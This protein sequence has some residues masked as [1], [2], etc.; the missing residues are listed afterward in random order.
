MDADP[1]PA[2]RIEL[3]AP[4]ASRLAS[5]TLLAEF[6]RSTDLRSFAIAARGRASE[7]GAFYA[8]YAIAEC[9][10]R[11][12]ASGEVVAPR[13]TPLDH[14]R[15][16]ARVASAERWAMR[17]AAFL[18]DELSDDAL[19]KVLASGARA[20]DPLLPVMADWGRAVEDGEL[21]SLR[22]AWHAVLQAGDPALL[23]WAIQ[24]GGDYL[25]AIVDMD[26]AADEPR[27]SAYLYTWD[28]VACELGAGCVTPRGPPD[29]L[30]ELLPRCARERWD[31]AALGATPASPL[32]STV[33][34]VQR[35]IAAMR[36]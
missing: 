27:R 35:T 8:A 16:Q 15:E 29:A 1:Q 9:R 34:E 14:R 23:D 36:R 30:C 26:P 25:H 6:A 7:G 28:A 5:R 3:T 22:R 24:S 31:I 18:P 20:N 21:A 12:P 32:A 2:P 10:L 4:P 17:C 33:H 13:S 19:D 11:P